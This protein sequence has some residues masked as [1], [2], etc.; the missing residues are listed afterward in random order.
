[1]FALD[2]S[3]YSNG[4]FDLI[5]CDL[6]GPYRTTALCGTRYFLTI[7]DDHSRAVWVYLLKDKTSVSRHIKDFLALVNKQFSKKVKTIRSDNGTEFIF[8][9]RFLQEN[10]KSHETSC[11]YT[12]Q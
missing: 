3:S 8:L 5:H 12:P 9:S 1:M 10:G 6:W 11:V 7:I 2:S 4:I